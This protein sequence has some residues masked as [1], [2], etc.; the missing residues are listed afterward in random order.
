MGSVLVNSMQS[1]PTVRPTS[2]VMQRTAV[3]TGLQFTSLLGV[4][5]QCRPR[6]EAIM[7]AHAIRQQQPS[8]ARDAWQE[9][10]AL[11]DSKELEADTKRPV[12]RGVCSGG[13]FCA[14][15]RDHAFY[16]ADYHE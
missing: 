4:L 10:V 5:Q 7:Y 16:F 6:L 9:R 14:E 3:D 8:E 1:R 2:A 12:G 13:P 11:L 15:S